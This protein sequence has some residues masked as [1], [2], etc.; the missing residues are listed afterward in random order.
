MGGGAILDEVHYLHFSAIP[1]D[2]RRFRQ[3]FD[4]VVAP[5]YVHIRVNDVQKMT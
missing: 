4:C 5:F 3:A 2:Y 1:L